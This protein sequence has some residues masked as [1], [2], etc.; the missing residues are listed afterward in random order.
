MLE[1]ISALSPGNKVALKLLRNQAEIDV[2][3]TV[4]KRPS[5]N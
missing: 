4:G 3:V 5:R 1:K 2:K